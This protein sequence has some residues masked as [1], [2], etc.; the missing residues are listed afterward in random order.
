MATTTPQLANATTVIAATRSNITA[1]AMMK[2]GNAV[3]RCFRYL[4]QHVLS[5]RALAID[6]DMPVVGA[7]ANGER[8]RVEAVWIV[9]RS[10]S[11]TEDKEPGTSH[12]SNNSDA[13][14]NRVTSATQSPDLR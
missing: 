2:K 5:I 1:T 7:K 9:H 8:N 14:N 11:I 4:T 6:F 12:S 3:G 10:R 13:L